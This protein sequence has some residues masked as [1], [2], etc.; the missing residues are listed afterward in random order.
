MTCREI[1]NDTLALV[2]EDPAAEYNGDY[3]ARAVN[4]LNVFTSL[5]YMNDV[6]YAGAAVTS[7]P[8]SELV[9]TDLDTE[10][11]LGEVF[12]AAAVCFLASMLI[13]SEN[14]DLSAKLYGVY[15]DD[16]KN[17]KRSTAAAV[18]AITDIY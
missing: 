10:F 14:P 12:T 8:L 1:Y 4:I 9:I 5:Q 6:D 7:T 15:D 17:I 2:G 18:N 13:S 16:I 11:P 3:L